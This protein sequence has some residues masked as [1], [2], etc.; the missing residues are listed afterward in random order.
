MTSPNLASGRTRTGPATGP[1][2][3]PAPASAAPAFRAAPT[4]RL[5]D[6]RTAV[7]ILF[8]TDVVT[9]LAVLTAVASWSP[10]LRHHL[11]NQLAFTAIT[12]ASVLLC[13]WAK[14]VYVR[15]RRHIVPSPADD[16]GA[17]AAAVLTSLLVVLA[18]RALFAHAIGASLPTSSVLLG[19][20]LC[21]AAIPAARTVSLA[22]HKR[23]GT[24]ATKVLVVGTGTIAA[25][26]GSRLT[27]A[28]HVELVGYVDDDPVDGQEVIGDLNAL[29][30]ICREQ[31]VDRVVVAFS[32]GHPRRMAEVLR[33]L[34]G[35]LPID[36]VPRYFELT[37]WEAVVDDLSG[38]ALVSL[39]GSRPGAFSLGAKR[40][41]DVV[42]A[43]L[44]LLVL[45]PILTVVGL[46][47]KMTSPG[48]V[49]FRQ[50]RLGRDGVP[51]EILKFRTMRDATPEEIRERRQR[52]GCDLLFDAG[53][54]G[55]RVTSIGRV[56]RR[57]GIDELPQLLNVLWGHMAMVGP[58]PFV[59]EECADL[60]G[61]ANKRFDFRPGLTGMWQ[62]CGQH[63]LRF[64][65]LCRLDCQYVDTWTFLADL[66]ILA[67]TPGRLLRGGKV[68]VGH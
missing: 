35:T 50:W 60:P 30:A 38:L 61:W 57:F 48:P 8:A 66:R 13:L 52:P 47:V 28:A 44:G 12:L 23:T 31:G 33:T 41:L 16:L 37:G 54:D 27:R 68:D 25:D 22:I 15:A 34:E 17:L 63:D 18:G 39:G 62:V 26:V 29:P 5:A 32:R 4:R 1:A 3:P 55:Q 11:G 19:L 6:R 43:S 67:R 20:A 65:E 42:G 2:T 49:L 53:K 40:A 46:A 36:V 58:R 51:F 9:A 10:P 56:L 21:L 14:R 64:D 7:V 45:A 24:Q 59:P